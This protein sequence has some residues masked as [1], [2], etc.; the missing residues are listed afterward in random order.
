VLIA[1]DDDVLAFPASEAVATMWAAVA[2]HGA[3]ELCAPARTTIALGE[4]SMT[5]TSGRLPGVASGFRLYSSAPEAPSEVTLIFQPGEEPI[6]IVVGK[7]LGRRRTGAL[8]GVAARLCAR[9]DARTIGFIGAGEQAYTQL[10]A[11]AAVRDL[12]LVR[13][14]SRSPGTAERFAAK[15]R[16]EL[17][18]TVEVVSAARAAVAG[19]DI[20]VL[21]TPAQSPLIEASWIEPGTHVHTLGPKGAAEGECPK[22]LVQ[23]AT[24]LVS[25][26]PVQLSAMEGPDAPWTGGRVADSL[27][28][29][30]IGAVP[31]RVSPDDIT[32]YASVGLAGTEVLLARRI[33][34]RAR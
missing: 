18:L 4:A 12:Q 14:H 26:S 27:G 34:D 21:S 13:V 16:T 9:E 22:E 3:G 7:T 28:E 31:G 29:I 15:A 30:L 25:D 2:A 8:G 17:G 24:L 5:L 32:L 33:L 23:S 19:S 1:T 11:I 20:L 10:W 6:G